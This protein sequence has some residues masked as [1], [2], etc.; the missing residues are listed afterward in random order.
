MPPKK[1][2][3]GKRK[4]AIRSGPGGRRSFASL[5]PEPFRNS[6]RKVVD[7]IVAGPNAER[8]ASLPGQRMRHLIGAE[9]IAL[10]HLQAFVGTMD[11]PRRANI[12]CD[13]VAAFQTESNRCFPMRRWRREQNRFI[14]KCGAELMSQALFSL[15]SVRS[16]PTMMVK[17]IMGSTTPSSDNRC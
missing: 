16:E 13:P 11:F 6:R 15:F 5:P 14:I 9:D 17:T 3:S 10:D 1:P 4:A 2:M 12:R 7:R 8:M